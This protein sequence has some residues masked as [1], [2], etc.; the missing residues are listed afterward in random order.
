MLPFYTLLLLGMTH[1]GHAVLCLLCA[2][3][4]DMLVPLIVATCVHTF[5]V[6]AHTLK[7]A[8]CTWNSFCKP[9]AQS[10]MQAEQETHLLL[11][12]ALLEMYVDKS[13]GPCM[14]PTLAC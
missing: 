13:H 8:F 7:K 4:L 1:S 10:F 2:S 14:Q 9:P 3:S 12:I 6:L 5:A 11:Q